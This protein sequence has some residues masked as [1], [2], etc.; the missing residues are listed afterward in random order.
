MS[1]ILNSD[2]AA[3]IVPALVAQLRIP[4][5][6]T[7]FRRRI[8]DCPERINVRRAARVLAGIGGLGPHLAGPE[9]ADGAVAPREYAVAGRVCICGADIVARVIAGWIGIDLVPCPAACLLRLDQA[10]DR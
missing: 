9:M 6:A 1:R 8:Q 7:T 2:G 3:R 10:R 4:V 5:D